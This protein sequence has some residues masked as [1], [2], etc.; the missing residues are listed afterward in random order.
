MKSWTKLGAFA[1]AMAISGTASAQTVGM[2]VG[3]AGFWTNSAGAAIAKVANDAGVKMRIEPSSGTTVY[4]PSINNGN[5]QFGLANHEEP[6]E[7]VHGTGLWTGKQLPNL[8]VVSVL[9]RVMART[10]CRMT[11]QLSPPR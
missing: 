4:V 7:A 10:L 9:A 11:V 2:G 8:R 1:V 3:V 5:L 6:F